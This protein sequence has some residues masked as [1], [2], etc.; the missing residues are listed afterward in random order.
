MR[1][2]FGKHDIDARDYIT[3]TRADGET[4]V[5]CTSHEPLKDAKLEKLK[6]WAR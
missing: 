3:H 5:Y 2:E 1:C 4:F 6:R